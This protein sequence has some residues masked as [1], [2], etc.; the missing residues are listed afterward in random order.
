M[1]LSKK[2]NDICEAALGRG[3]NKPLAKKY[4]FKIE[5]LN[6]EY[7]R[8]MKYPRIYTFQREKIYKTL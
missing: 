5:K 4:E 7:R 3:K 6:S 1:R 8:E 2:L